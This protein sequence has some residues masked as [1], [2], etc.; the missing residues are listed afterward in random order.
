M[1]LHILDVEYQHIFNSYSKYD[2]SC[3]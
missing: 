2:P 3:K 1:A